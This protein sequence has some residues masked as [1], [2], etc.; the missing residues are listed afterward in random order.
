MQQASQAHRFRLQ[1]KTL[2]IKELRQILRDKSL[3]FLLFAILLL[4]KEKDTFKF[5]I[6][7]LNLNSSETVVAW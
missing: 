3:L 1:I 6:K 7:L 2:A 4:L 5:V